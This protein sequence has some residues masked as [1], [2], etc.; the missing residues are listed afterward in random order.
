MERD[1][2]IGYG[3][4]S[5]LME[6]LMISSDV[7]SAT[8]CQVS[9]LIISFQSAISFFGM[10]FTNMLIYFKHIDLWPSGLSGEVQLL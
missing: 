3:A 9:N 7:Y 5:L 1:C 8:V 10:F 6:R 2:L 4:S